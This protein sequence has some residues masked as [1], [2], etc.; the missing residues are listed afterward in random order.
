MNAFAAAGREGDR[1][2]AA[3]LLAR[4]LIARGNIGG[5]SGVLAQVPSPEGRALPI[6]AVVQFRLARCLVAANEGRRA[7]AGRTMDTIAA[8]VS[9]LGLPPLEKET[10]LAQEAVMKIAST[11]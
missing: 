6:K 10:R 3:A 5:A 9:R 2:E 8:E 7:E 4:A 1:L 11:H